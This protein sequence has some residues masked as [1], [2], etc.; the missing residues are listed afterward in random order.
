MMIGIMFDRLS[1]GI[2]S[3]MKI[4]YKIFIKTANL[5]VQKTPLQS[6]AFKKHRFYC[7]AFN[8]LAKCMLRTQKDSKKSN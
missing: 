4:N 6:G 1:V 8:A 7:A 5:H 3:K 2:I